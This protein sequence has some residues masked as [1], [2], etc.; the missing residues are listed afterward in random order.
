MHNASVLHCLARASSRGLW[1]IALSL[2][3]VVIDGSLLAQ[4]APQQL[5]L[6]QAG[7]LAY[8]GSFTLPATD[9]TNRSPAEQSAL[10]YGGFALGVGPGGQ[11]L[12]YGCHDWHSM[13][14]RVTIPQTGGVASVIEPCASVPNLQAV[15]GTDSGARVL[16]GSLWWNGRLIVSGFSYYDADL[17]ASA[18][19]FF[20]PSVGQLTGPVRLQ[21]AIP[22]MV[23]GYMGVVPQEWRSLLGGPALT[24]QCCLSIIS[25]T[26]YRP[27]VSVFNPD[28]FGAVSP[29]PSTLLLGYTQAHPL[30]TYNGQSDLFNT[31]A[32]VG[33]VAFPAGTRSVLFVGRIGTG[34]VCYGPGAVCGD[35][36][37]DS[38][39]YHAHPY[40]Q[41]VWAYDAN[42]L[43]AVKQ[44]R[45]QSWEVRPYGVWPLPDLPNGDGRGS[46]RSAVYDHGTRRLYVVS[47]AGSAAPRVHVYLITTAVLQPPPQA[48]QAF[49]SKVS[50]NVAS[51]SWLPPSSSD[52][53]GYV[54]EA[55]SSPGN[56]DL[57]T[58]PVSALARTLSLS[59]PVG[60]YYVRLKSLLASGL[61]ATSTELRVVV[62]GPQLALPAAPSSLRA[63]AAADAIAFSWT[64]PQDPSVDAIILEAGSAPGRSDYLSGYSVGLAGAFMATGVA[65]GK[66]YARLR[67]H[68][69]SGVSLASNE[70]AVTAGIWP[71][72][73]LPPNG[74]SASV[75]NRVVSLKWAAAT[76]GGP[77]LSYSIEAGSQL[78]LADL[79]VV[80]TSIVP[81]YSTSVQ[82]GTYFVRVRASNPVGTSL[83][84]ADVRVTVD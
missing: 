57:G 38:S 52:L 3:G 62:G 33:G 61:S 84:S 55:G 7:N 56:T 76:G 53:G 23:A 37:F 51:F 27:S 29:V 66:Y 45:K 25:R 46:F 43:L 5:P 34:Q 2:L 77:A 16:G 35:P 18:S 79:A 11:S 26:S 75:V 49:A 68:N 58:L 28:H 17:D 20:G 39:G 63:V 67:S 80:S 9:G 65:P 15:D 36:A 50:G 81:A 48:P 82:P 69:A 83:P 22:G 32:R 13:L 8:L 64:A 4:T 78:G 30:A 70:V 44:G 42:D 59:A 24:G 14:A 10:T 73:P 19:H 21:G 60:T 31:T 12:Y 47:D 41:Q 54:F 6:V 74:L 72:L 71:A 1:V 40:R